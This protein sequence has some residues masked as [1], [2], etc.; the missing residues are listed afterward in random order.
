[1]PAW[2]PLLGNLAVMANIPKLGPSDSRQSDTVA[3]YA[4]STKG[5]EGGFY[6]DVWPFGPR[7]LVVTSPAMAIQ[8][9]QTFDLPKP[10]ILHPFI[11]PMAGSSDNLFVTNG[12]RWKS[13]RDLFNHGF[14][15]AAS[16]S[17]M[18]SV[19]EEAQAYARVLKGLAKKGDT[20]LLD[21]LT[22]AYAMDIVG[23]ITL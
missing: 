10:K 4:S 12:A 3:Y 7:V 17:H 23:H 8:T 13:A 19:V 14:S 22:C 6:I 2:N 16:F 5:M 15:M 1:M 20:F 11:N 9:C 18:K 21:P